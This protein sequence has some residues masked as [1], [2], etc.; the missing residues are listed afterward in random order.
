[1]QN[2]TLGHHTGGTMGLP[3]RALN[4]PIGDTPSRNTDNT[5]RQL[6]TPHQ[7]NQG[8]GAHLIPPST[9]SR[10]SPY[11][12]QTQN[13]SAYPPQQNPHA[14][15][16]GQFNYGSTP[17][18][19]LISDDKTFERGMEYGATKRD[20]IRLQEEVQ[21][22]RENQRKEQ[23][24]QENDQ[25][26]QM[27]RI[28][29]TVSTIHS[30]VRR[31]ITQLSGVEAGLST[32]Q[33]VQ[34]N[35]VNL[36]RDVQVAQQ[37]HI[38]QTRHVRDV[39]QE[40]ISQTRHVEE[41][42]A[43]IRFNLREE[44][45]TVMS[46]IGTSL[47]EGDVTSVDSRIVEAIFR[48]RNQIQDLTPLQRQRLDG[49]NGERDRGE[50]DLSTLT[51]YVARNGTGSLVQDDFFVPL[52]RYV[53]SVING[54]RTPSPSVVIFADSFRAGMVFEPMVDDGSSNGSDDSNLND[55]D[56]ISDVSTPLGMS[57]ILN[58][59]I[60]VV[61]SDSGSRD[62]S[63]TIS[64]DG[65]QE[66][67]MLN[68][69]LAAIANATSEIVQVSLTSRNS[70][71]PVEL[72][73]SEDHFR[74]VLSM[75]IS[76]LEFN[77]VRLTEGG[78]MGQGNPSDHLHN[79]RGLII[80]NKSKFGMGG[81]YVLQ[82]NGGGLR[83]VIR[84]ASSFDTRLLCSALVNKNQFENGSTV[85]AV[86]SLAIEHSALSSEDVIELAGAAARMGWS[87]S[88]DE[89]TQGSRFMLTISGYSKSITKKCSD[90]FP[91]PGDDGSEPS[92]DGNDDGDSSRGPFD[93]RF[94]DDGDDDASGGC[95]DDDDDDD[96]DDG[97]Q[98]NVASASSPSMGTGAF[99]HTSSWG[100]SF[101][102]PV[103]GQWKCDTCF[104]TNEPSA[105]EKCAA[106]ETPKPGA[107]GAPFAGAE[108]SSEV[109]IP[110]SIPGTIGP[111]GFSFG[112]NGKETHAAEISTGGANGPNALS[113]TFGSK[114][115]NGTSAPG[116]SI[117]P[118]S[119]VTKVCIPVHF[120][121]F[122]Y[123]NSFLSDLLLT[124]YSHYFC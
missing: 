73:L 66:R 74:R 6:F 116:I 67:E 112:G 27:S 4:N 32:V 100:A 15:Q 81:R 13:H 26:G 109:P 3:P 113:T 80:L 44:I 23:Q 35:H 121:S 92:D 108:K 51:F 39:Q 22:L 45:T 20:N 82:G 76:I 57:R 68:S 40:H 114:H 56:F 94:K 107:D 14:T 106:C 5:R 86:E 69:V 61:T 28:E 89:N 102:S 71:E 75:D 7:A 58:V 95:G 17:Q 123:V 18:E 77:C 117:G 25:Q 118:G 33:D 72:S 50:V 84:L 10:L 47:G 63:L 19:R 83:L 36:T 98:A 96:D 21:R 105:T 24:R 110:N 53:T 55:A 87:F 9:E 64:S 8:Q 103:N 43:E 30:N 16:S 88:S 29:H 41:L 12:N 1:M 37:E 120:E 111:N 93:N 54:E 85:G 52:A 42:A 91:D 122:S 90:K 60:R 59:D 48:A 101:G 2:L 124:S 97:A 38:S 78:G 119:A 65:H 31:G 62:I 11:P 115:D 49:A 70:E 46:R 99:A 104:T 79:Y 34:R